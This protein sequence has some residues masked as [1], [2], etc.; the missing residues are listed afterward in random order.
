[1]KAHLTFSGTTSGIKRK[2]SSTEGKNWMTTNRKTSDRN[3][4]T[5][6]IP[7]PPCVLNA[8]SQAQGYRGPNVLRV[9]MLLLA[10]LSRN[11][12]DF[13]LLKELEEENGVS[14]SVGH[15]AL[16]IIITVLEDT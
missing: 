13:H 16:Q 15:A 10:A 8:G 14:K 7:P 12:Y 9:I 6:T 5:V 4:H 1:M 3:S 11:R 2:L